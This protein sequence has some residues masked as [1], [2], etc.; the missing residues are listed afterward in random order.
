MSCGKEITLT[1]F[2]NVL[3]LLLQHPAYRDDAK[4]LQFLDALLR[5]FESD[6]CSEYG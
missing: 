2:Y 4:R 5:A 1:Q 3:R 6:Y